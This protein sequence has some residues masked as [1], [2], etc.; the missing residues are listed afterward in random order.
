MVHTIPTPSSLVRALHKSMA[1]RNPRFAAR[2]AVRA[3][4][5]KAN[6]KLRFDANCRKGGFIYACLVEA[7]LA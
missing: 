5:E 4:Q 7:F 3:G 2:V 1:E 6:A